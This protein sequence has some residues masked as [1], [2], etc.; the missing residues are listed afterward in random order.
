MARCLQLK[1]FSLCLEHLKGKRAKIG[2][3]LRRPMS[4]FVSRSRMLWK[5]SR[6]VQQSIALI[7]HLISE[8]GQIT[9]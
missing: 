2:S 7:G 3:T 5:T 1:L 4:C 6:G 9:R 8:L